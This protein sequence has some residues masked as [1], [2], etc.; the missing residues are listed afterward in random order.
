MTSEEQQRLIAMGMNAEQLKKNPALEECFNY[1]LDSL[2]AEWCTTEP[3]DSEDRLAIWATAQA[4]TVFK[5]TVDLYISQGKF[6]Q[7]EKQ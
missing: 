7:A 5:N 4:L 6:E 1:T 2:F 3:K